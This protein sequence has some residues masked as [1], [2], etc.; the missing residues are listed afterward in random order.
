MS[1][2]I[3]EIHRKDCD[4]FRKIALLE[5]VGGSMSENLPPTYHSLLGGTQKSL[6][7]GRMTI[8]SGC[9]RA[10]AQ[11]LTICKLREQ[12]FDG[13][14]DGTRRT[15]LRLRSYRQRKEYQEAPITAD[16]RPF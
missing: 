4:N 8:V 9:R 1:F 12:E 3:T 10:D 6:A 14:S 15:L 5:G 16:I 11:N 2:Y 7:Q 13:L